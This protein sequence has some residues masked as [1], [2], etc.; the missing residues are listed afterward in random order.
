MPN[1]HLFLIYKLGMTGLLY[2][3]INTPNS[4]SL[5]TVSLSLDTNLEMKAIILLPTDW[6]HSRVDQK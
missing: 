3:V 4:H 6:S 2:L 1:V 5:E